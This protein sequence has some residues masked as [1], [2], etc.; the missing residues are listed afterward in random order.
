MMMQIMSANKNIR[1]ACF[2]CF[3]A[4]S[5]SY[6]AQQA[7]A[8]D[9]D[10]A[11]SKTDPAIAGVSYDVTVLMRDYEARESASLSRSGHSQW[12]SAV[13]GY[14]VKDA[15]S[16]SFRQRDP[17]TTPLD[18]SMARRRYEQKL[19]QDEAR[20]P[21]VAA[22]FKEHVQR[23]AEDLTGGV[24]SWAKM[25]MRNEDGASLL[26]FKTDIKP[27]FRFGNPADSGLDVK[28][29]FTSDYVSPRL[30]MTAEFQADNMRKSFSGSATRDESAAG[31]FLRWKGTPAE[32]YEDVVVRPSRVLGL[33]D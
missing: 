17:V 19:Q 33:G 27:H 22:S 11:V 5:I 24:T 16:G 29:S 25:D 18:E 15:G 21:Q 4:A 6:Q 8:E 7:F 9:V 14:G 28:L 2:V 20:K 12:Y 23:V 30:T 13:A 3:F 32:F 10:Y 31:V 1:A 26:R